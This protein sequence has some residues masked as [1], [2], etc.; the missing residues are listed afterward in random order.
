VP[1]TIQT[2]HA[3]SLPRPDD[4]IE[5]NRRR[6]DGEGVDEETYAHALRDATVDVVRRQR[7]IGIDL[8]NDGEYG[9]AMGQKVDYGAWWSYIYSRLGGVDHSEQMEDTPR[10]DPAST[11]KLGT[12]LE[13]R[14]WKR[15]PDAYFDPEVGILTGVRGGGRRRRGSPS[16]SAWNR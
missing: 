12:F 15:F 5:L 2:S 6:M 14:D 10:A 4:L 9:H 13:R 8:P 11:I 7:D 16:P 3:G 1:P